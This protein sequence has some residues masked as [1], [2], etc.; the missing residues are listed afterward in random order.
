ME[1]LKKFLKSILDL[2]KKG[3]KWIGND[4]LLN[5]ETSALLVLVLMFFLPALWS[6][7]FGFIIVVIKCLLDKSKGHD[8]EM[9]DLI[10]ATIGLIIGTFIGLLI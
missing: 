4:G 9:H 8:K 1:F 5:M 10:C 7:I 2:D 3:R 6:F